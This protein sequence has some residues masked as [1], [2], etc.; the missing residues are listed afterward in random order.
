MEENG[1]LKIG[2]PSSLVHPTGRQSG[3]LNQLFLFHN[4]GLVRGL[5]HV[6]VKMKLIR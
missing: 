4:A 2:R 1:E 5:R 3:G 6:G